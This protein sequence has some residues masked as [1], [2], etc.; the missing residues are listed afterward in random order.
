MNEVAVNTQRQVSVAT[1]IADPWVYG[2][3]LALSCSLG[4]QTLTF[5]T[6]HSPAG[7]SVGVASLN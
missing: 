5:E 3:V 2:L 7:L 4:L 6:V 1:L